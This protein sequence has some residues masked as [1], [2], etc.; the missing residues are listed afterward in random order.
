MIDLDKMKAELT[1]DEGLRQR[2]YKDNA[3][4]PRNTIG[5]GRNLDDVG[6]SIEEAQ[7]LLANDIK[8]AIEQ[9]DANLPWWQNLD[10]TRQR[11]MVNMCFNLGIKRFL[12]FQNTLTFIKNGDYDSAAD[13]MLKSAWA[14][15][16]GARA[17]RLSQM[18]ETGNS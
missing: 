16:V 7:Y 1:R 17:Q 12:G 13:E 4:P 10:G 15:Q 2:L 6:V 14:G 9:L 11:V 18:M 5:V 3:T 8:R